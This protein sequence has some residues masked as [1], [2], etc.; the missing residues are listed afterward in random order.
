MV[1]TCFKYTRVLQHVNAKDGERELVSSLKQE[2]KI[3]RD[4]GTTQLIKEGE[5]DIHR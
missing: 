3:R 4:T 2:K 1:K 5:K